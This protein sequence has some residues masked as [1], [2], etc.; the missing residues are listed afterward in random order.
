MSFHKANAEGR[1]ERLTALRTV[2]PD[3]DS[4]SIIHFVGASPDDIL[5]AFVAAWSARRWLTK[6]HQQLGGDT[7][8]RGLRMEMI[9]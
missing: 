4:Q 7:D 1:S 8:E 3:I 5:D 2:F 9:A 6:T